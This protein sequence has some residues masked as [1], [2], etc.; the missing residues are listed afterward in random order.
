MTPLTIS[1]DAE[2]TPLDFGTGLVANGR[3][4]A[5]GLLRNGTANGKA[6][7]AV[8][9]TLADGSTVLGETTWALLRTA[10]NGLAASPTVAEEV[11]DP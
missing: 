10:V 7:V 8:V 5:I 6:S 2:Q 1:T 4:S 3:L 9:I 11:V